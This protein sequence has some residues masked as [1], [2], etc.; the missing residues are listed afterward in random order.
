MSEAFLLTIS[1]ISAGLIGL[2]LVGMT[3]YIQTGDDRHE[4]SR[5]VVE[6]YF[7]AATLI[8]FI[9]YSVP[10]AVSLTL[11]ALPFEWSLILYWVL[12]IGL[13]VV[14]VRT[15]STVRDVQRE[16]GLSLLTMVEV[17]GT[18]AI[19]AMILL[20]IVTGGLDPAQEDLVPGLLIGMGIAFLGTCVLVLSLFDIA[21]FERSHPTVAGPVGASEV[22]ATAEDTDPGDTHPVDDPEAAP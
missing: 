6:P 9:A 12:V 16:V 5:H 7:R 2:F 3:I 4:R 13:L 8:T 20:P 19:A 1:S 15:V 18:L 10:L 14:N 22:D 21:R 11:V 17:V